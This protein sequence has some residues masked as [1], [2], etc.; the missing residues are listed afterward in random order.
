M[1]FGH[2]NLSKENADEHIKNCPGKV[3]IIHGKDDTLVPYT[4]SYRLYEKFK[5]KIEY[6]LFEGA[7]HGLS[8]IS[9]KEKYNQII[10]K[11]L[12]EE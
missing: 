11:F 8:Y 1:I 6:A 7:E 12:A 9:N 2:V 5:D 4:F 3:L 10:D